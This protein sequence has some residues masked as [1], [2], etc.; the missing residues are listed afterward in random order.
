MTARDVGILG[1]DRGLPRRT[2]RHGLVLP[3]RP[4][5]CGIVLGGRAQSPRTD[6]PTAGSVSNQ[7]ARR[8]VVPFR[9]SRRRAAVG[10]VR[11]AARAFFYNTVFFTYA[12]VLGR[13]RGI[14]TTQ[15]GLYFCRWHTEASWDRSCSGGSS[16]RSALPMGWTA[17]SRTLQSLELLT[18]PYRF[19]APRHSCGQKRVAKHTRL[20][21]TAN[22]AR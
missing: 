17:R 5:G 19:A 1:H 16:T 15:I 12:L 8:A 7:L 18:A 2:A 22:Q 3:G 9:S 14:E 6:F 4:A 13:F 11:I 20:N 21:A 10:L